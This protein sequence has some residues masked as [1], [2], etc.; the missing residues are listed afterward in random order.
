MESV[1]ICSNRSR[2]GESTFARRALEGRSVPTCSHAEFLR[3]VKKG[4]KII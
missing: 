1:T 4:E 2:S 3:G